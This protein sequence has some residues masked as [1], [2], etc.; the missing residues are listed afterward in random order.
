MSLALDLAQ[1]IAR[2]RYEDLPPAAVDGCKAAVLD[3]VGVALAG[4]AEDA[5]IGRIRRMTQSSSPGAGMEPGGMAR[6][7]PAL[8]RP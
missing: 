7:G 6:A 2:M 5:E 3:T 4:A 8:A 1:R